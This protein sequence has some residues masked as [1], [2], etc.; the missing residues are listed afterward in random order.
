M[1]VNTNE[2][3]RIPSIMYQKI[4]SSCQIILKTQNAQNKERKLNA[5]RD[6]Q[7]TYKDRPIRITTNFSPETINAKW[8]W[9]DVIQTL[10]EHKWQPRLLYPA[11]HSITV[12]GEIKILYD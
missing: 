5:V 6:D 3:N 10:R 2:A 9:E 4:Y 7:I 12:D 8:S 1:P 11:K